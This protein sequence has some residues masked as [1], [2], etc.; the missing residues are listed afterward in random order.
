MERIR[1]ARNLTQDE[2]ATRTALSRTVIQ[3]TE[4]GKT[5][6]HFSTLLELARALDMDIM[7][8][9]TAL[10]QELEWFIQAEGKCLGHPPGIRAIGVQALKDAYGFH[11]YT[12]RGQ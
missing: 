5:D 7:L 2:L 12:P 8:V 11:R 3:Q 1:K 10:R 6:P 4:S 9:P